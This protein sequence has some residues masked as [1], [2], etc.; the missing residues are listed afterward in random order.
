MRRSFKILAIGG[1]ME[2]FVLF[3]LLIYHIFFY[4]APYNF[5]LEVWGNLIHPVLFGGLAVLL[6]GTIIFYKDRKK[7]QKV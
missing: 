1:S 3:S 4:H 6:A 7:I 2:L 5:L